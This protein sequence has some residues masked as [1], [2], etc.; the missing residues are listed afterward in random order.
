MPLSRR[1]RGTQLKTSDFSRKITAKVEQ[2]VMGDGVAVD[3]V[4]HLRDQIFEPILLA[5]RKI[6]PKGRNDMS[7]SLQ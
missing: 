4:S 5:N 6:I 2:S 3:V 1:M 7:N